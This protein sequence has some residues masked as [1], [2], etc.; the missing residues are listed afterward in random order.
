[1]ARRTMAVRQ[2]R[3]AAREQRRTELE[4]LLARLDRHT[5]LDTERPLIRA[6]V[7]QLLATDAD[8]RRTIAGQQTLVQRQA[9]QLDAA[10]E[11]IRE[12]EQ[13]AAEWKKT[14]ATYSGL[15]SSAEQDVADLREQLHAYRAVEAQRQADADTYAGRLDAL[16]QQTG[17]ALLAGAEEA[18][19]RALTAEVTLG[20]VRALAHRMRAGSP[21][22]AAAVY[23]DRIEQ[24]LDTTPEPQS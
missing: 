12:A 23:A 1:M 17:E 14:A 15:H 22:G 24:T 18:L 7:E 21:Q 20:R 10:H 13:D 16:R 3:A 6:H 5:L 8:L 4:H 19:R 2:A 11:A 9:R